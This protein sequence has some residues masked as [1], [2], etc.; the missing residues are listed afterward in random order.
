[1]RFS[2]D[3]LYKVDRIFLY[4]RENFVKR[5]KFSF[6]TG[7]KLW[8]NKNVGAKRTA[9]P[10]FV[11]ETIK[12]VIYRRGVFSPPATRTK[13]K[14]PRFCEGKFPEWPGPKVAPTEPRMTH[15]PDGAGRIFPSCTNQ[16]ASAQNNTHKSTSNR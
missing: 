2:I 15:S 7:A 5:H 16:S 11:F 4:I 3:F 8:Y 1:M 9:C 6:T 10:C 13:N 12:S 14:R